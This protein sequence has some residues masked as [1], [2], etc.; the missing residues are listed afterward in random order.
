MIDADIHKGPAL[1]ADHTAQLVFDQAPRRQTRLRIGQTLTLRTGQRILHAQFQFLDVKRLGDVIHRLQF[2]TLQFIAA[3][4]FLRQENDGD[5]AG[6]RIG[7]QCAA[8]L[9]A[10]NIRQHDIQHD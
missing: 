8:Y 6:A 7:A 10:I 2:E 5:M 3:L 4:V 9:I 1:L